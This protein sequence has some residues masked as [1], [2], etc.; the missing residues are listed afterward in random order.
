VRYKS[1]LLLIPLCFAACGYSTSG[2]TAKDIKSIAVPFFNNLTTEPD[3][4]INVTERIINNLVEDNTLKVVEEEN[5]DAVL[6]GDIVE[7]TNTPFSFNVDLNA[8]EYRVVLVVKVTLH[9]RTLNEPIW[10]DQRITGDAAYF[11]DA[12]EAG[13]TY[14]DA[15][16][17][18]I[19]EI[20][21]QILNLTVQD[22]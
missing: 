12:A 3:L 2:R 18:S 16:E 11:L 13:L 14:E 8:D 10:Q 17:E 5:A 22:W 4:E 15:L 1:L 7:F 20:T 9:N 21:E 19:E 6:E